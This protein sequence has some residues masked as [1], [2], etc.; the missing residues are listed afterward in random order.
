L[1]WDQVKESVTKLEADTG[2]DLSWTTLLTVEIGTSIVVKEKPSGTRLGGQKLLA[3]DK[4]KEAEQ[5]GLWIPST[6]KGRNIIRLEYRI[7]NKQTIQQKFGRDLMVSDL[8][9]PKV[10]R[11]LRKLFFRFYT[12]IPK[13][14]HR[15]IMNR[16]TVREILD[17]SDEA[18]LPP[19]AEIRK[20]PG[21]DQS[22]TIPQRRILWAE[23][24]RQRHHDEYLD[25]EHSLLENR[26]ITKKTHEKI[27][28]DDWDRDSTYKFSENDDLI[29]ELDFKMRRQVRDVKD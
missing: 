1:T 29:Q 4:V 14:G 9:E 27:N 7:M 20:N 16:P 22:I 5:N 13:A 2:I 28:H 23:L 21:V 6:Y 24:Q 17:L 25:F 18:D 3:Y 11:E 12:A 26:M 15:V 19:E 10:I 8:W